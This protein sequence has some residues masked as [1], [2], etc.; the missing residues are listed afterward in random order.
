M[1][2]TFSFVKELSQQKFDNEN[3]MGQIFCNPELFHGFSRVELVKLLNL[4]VKNC[5]FIFNGKFYDQVGVAMGSALDPLL[6]NI[7]LS[8][9]EIKWLKDCP[10]HFK[11]LHYRR[12][13]DDSV[14]VFRSRNNIISF[15]EY[16]NSK[17]P[18]I[19]FTYEIKKDHYLPFLDVNT[20][21]SDG[22]LSTSVTGSLRLRVCFL[23]L[24]V[25]FLFRT[26]K[27]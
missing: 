15:L 14:V 2:D 23:I 6:A 24:I 21:F 25:S 1:P 13:V 19:K 8:F 18:N 16:L 7:F 5:H 17:H 26:K 12:Y 10:V 4:A 9:H 20:V 3:V 22:I 11:P 27:V